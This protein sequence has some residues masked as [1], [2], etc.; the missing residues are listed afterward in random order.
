MQSN[1][2]LTVEMNPVISDLQQLLVISGWGNIGIESLNQHAKVIDAQGRYI[3]DLKK[4]LEQEIQ[5]QNTDIDPIDQQLAELN[6]LAEQL[7]SLQKKAFTVKGNYQNLHHA[8]DE[9]IHSRQLVENHCRQLEGKNQLL[10]K[11]IAEQQNRQTGHRQAIEESKQ[12]THTHDNSLETV[13]KD[14]QGVQKDLNDQKTMTVQIKHH[15]EE[16]ASKIDRMKAEMFESE[17]QYSTELS[18]CSSQYNK[19]KTALDQR[20]KS[21]QE[22]LTKTFAESKDGI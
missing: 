22:Q 18:E 10:Q 8:L 6:R 15:S 4:R 2:V 13:K 11:S 21:V 9:A 16:L 17:K 5:S 1:N 12:K 7:S 20:M 14:Q 19:D 3:V